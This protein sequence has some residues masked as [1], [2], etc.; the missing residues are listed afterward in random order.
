MT[1]VT[2]SYVSLSNIQT[3]YHLQITL[4]FKCAINISFRPH[5]SQVIWRR[6][7]PGKTSPEKRAGLS[8]ETEQ[9][10]LPQHLLH[11]HQVHR[12]HQPKALS[13]Y[14]HLVPVPP[15]RIYSDHHSHL[16][17]LHHDYPLFHLLPHCQI[18]PSCRHLSLSLTSA[19]N[20][21]ML[22]SLRSS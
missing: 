7:L 13:P 19:V 18:S 9:Q 11:S 17:K 4:C 2:P 1:Y 21:V 20:Q 5:T 3:A 6:I 16:S 12:H 14:Q 8:L 15:L 10:Q 22:S